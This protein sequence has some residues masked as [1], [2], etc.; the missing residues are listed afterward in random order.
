MSLLHCT[1]DST[2]M[3]F[4]DW[5]ES[6]KYIILKKTTAPTNEPSWVNIPFNRRAVCE[7]IGSACSWTAMPTLVCET[8]LVKVTLTI[9]YRKR[10]TN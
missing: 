2:R 7:S 8:I 1:C 5:N 9:T 10:K 6:V 4:Y 3:G